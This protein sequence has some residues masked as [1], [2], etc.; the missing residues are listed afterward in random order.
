MCALASVGAVSSDSRVNVIA[1]LLLLSALAVQ[2]AADICLFDRPWAG[3]QTGRNER[4][5]LDTG[6]K[7]SFQAYFGVPGAYSL[8]DSSD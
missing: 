2:R 4:P 7:K 1:A 6:S 3:C 5:Q 8:C